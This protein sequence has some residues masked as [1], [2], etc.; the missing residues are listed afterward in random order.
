MIYIVYARVCKVL[1]QLVESRRQVPNLTI[2]TA[3]NDT[4]E[5]LVLGDVEIAQCASNLLRLLEIATELTGKA[6]QTGRIQCQVTGI[7]GCRGRQRGRTMRQ[8]TKICRRLHRQVAE[9]GWRARPAMEAVQ[10]GKL[11]DRQ[12]LYVEMKTDAEWRQLLQTHC[13]IYYIYICEYCN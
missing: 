5:H 12:E 2:D 13:E 9:T 6:G 11:R 10:R 7:I 8:E 3:G 4:A 1:L